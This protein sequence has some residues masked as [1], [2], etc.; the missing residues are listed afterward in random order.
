VLL[1]FSHVLQHWAPATGLVSW[2][3]SQP[4]PLICVRFAV[5]LLCRVEV[6]TYGVAKQLP[7]ALCLLDFPGQVGKAWVPV[8]P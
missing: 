8:L 6:D 7:F 5:A 1:L 4:P 3:G 2:H